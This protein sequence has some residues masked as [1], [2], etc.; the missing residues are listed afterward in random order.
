MRFDTA[1]VWHQEAIYIY[2][3]NGKQEKEYKILLHW[4]FRL[5]LSGYIKYLNFVCVSIC[6]HI[7]SM[8]HSLS[9]THTQSLCAREIGGQWAWVC[10]SMGQCSTQCK[11]SASTFFLLLRTVQYILKLFKFPFHPQKFAFIRIER[12]NVIIKVRE[13]KKKTHEK[14]NHRCCRSRRRRRH[15]IFLSTVHFSDSRLLY[16]PNTRVSASEKDSREYHERIHANA[17]ISVCIQ[18]ILILISCEFMVF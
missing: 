2:G 11:W 15:I 3:Q 13:E 10:V 14:E 7:S 1:I 8:S 9:R 18:K 16:E 5:S 4:N 17:H 6:I 12:M